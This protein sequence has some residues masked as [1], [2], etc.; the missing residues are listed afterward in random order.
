MIPIIIKE[1]TK[2][3]S[4]TKSVSTEKSKE[5]WKKFDS[6]IHQILM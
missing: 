6:L 5:F 4:T 3:V 2:P 1:K